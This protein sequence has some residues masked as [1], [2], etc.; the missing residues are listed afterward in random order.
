MRVNCIQGE[1]TSFLGEHVVG[2]NITVFRKTCLLKCE[3]WRRNVFM[4]ILYILFPVY[5][6]IRPLLLFCTTAV[7]LVHKIFR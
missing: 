7:S 5:V 2:V 3:E 6:G 4:L 1:A